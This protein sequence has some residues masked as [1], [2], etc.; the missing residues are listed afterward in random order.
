[1]LKEQLPAANNAVEERNR[2]EK[3]RK[4]HSNIW[5]QSMSIIQYLNTIINFIIEPETDACAYIAREIE[6]ECL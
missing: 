6:K 4:S 5:A 2:K 1:M 3:N